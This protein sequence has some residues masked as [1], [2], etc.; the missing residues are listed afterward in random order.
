MRIVFLPS[1]AILTAT[2]FATHAS[3]QETPAPESTAAPAA[4]TA[5]PSAPVVSP[6]KPV[7][8]KTP[9]T[10]VAA[11]SP[12]A[13][14]TPQGRLPIGTIHSMVAELR[15][16]VEYQTVRSV[17]IEARGNMATAQRDE[18]R[19]G[20]ER[21]ADHVSVQMARVE[22]AMHAVAAKPVDV[23][24]LTEEVRALR[25]TA[26]EGADDIAGILTHDDRTE[27]TLQDIADCFEEIEQAADDFLEDLEELVDEPETHGS[28]E[29]TVDSET[30]SLRIRAGN[31]DLVS[32]GNAVEVKLGEIVRDAVSFG[33][34]VSVK[35][36]VTGSAVAFGG[37]VHVA[38]GGVVDGDAAAFGGTIIVDDGGRVDGEK[39]S[40]GPG[41]LLSPFKSSHG[42]RPAIAPW[43]TRM[44]G[45]LLAAGAQFVCFFLGGLLLL[46]VAPR[47]TQAVADALAAH[48]FKAGGVGILAAIA[49]LPITVL[50]AVTIIGLLLIPFFWLLYP[51]A[52]FLGYVAL[53]LIVGR[54]LPTKV[55]PTHTALL[56]IG[57]AVIVGIGLVPVLGK[58]IWFFAAFFALGAALMTRFGQPVADP[59]PYTATDVTSAA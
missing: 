29:V 38:K 16:A 55:I 52:G 22:K 32:Y 6:R 26:S 35:G 15:A 56:A 24:Q 5:P 17:S 50:L 4:P 47:R 14:A 21:A 30:G 33:N 39:I 2:L 13:S 44:G 3:A 11:A 51:A 34:N 20:R 48:P 53:A 10:P 7:A 8:P 9:A 57:A 54:K 1:F 28:V 42:P 36:T 41:A 23:V 40:F 49:W 25:S 43:P 37:D 19:R 59:A 12:E 18:I 27:D 58:L 46:A 31:S 45:K